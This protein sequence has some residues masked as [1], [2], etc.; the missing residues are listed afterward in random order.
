M[1]RKS[2]A[3]IY[4]ITNTVNG[5][6]YIG[7]AS[8]TGGRFKAHQYRL[9]AGSHHSVKLQRAWDKYGEAAFVFEIIERVED[10]SLIER[11]QHWIDHYDA[12][13]SGYNVASVAGR[14]AGVL[15]SEERKRA[16]SER[17]LGVPKSP[18]HRSAMS[19]CRV[20]KKH[21]EET[22]RRISERARA[23]YQDPEQAAKAG[24]HNLGRKHS[25]EVRQRM[26]AAHVA[27]YTPE[28]RAKCAE[29]ARGRKHTEEAKAKIAESNRRRIY[30]P[31]TLKKMSDSAKAAAARK[32]AER[33]GEVVPA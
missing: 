18:E 20:G 8:C 9:R 26:S 7:S 25:E 22:R 24:R 10:G 29:R 28:E 14:T 15:W 5:K 13:R 3:G 12:A 6:V 4:R 17:M 31:E 32:R 2:I 16:A 21:S 27:R 11:E 1:P 23:R 30:S 19:A 33:N